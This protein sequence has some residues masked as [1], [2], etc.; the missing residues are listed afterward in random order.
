MIRAIAD[1]EIIKGTEKMWTKELL[2]D[3][4][5]RRKGQA[6][7]TEKSLLKIRMKRGDITSKEYYEIIEET[8]EYYK[9]WKDF[10]EPKKRQRR[11]GLR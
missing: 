7:K 6:L 1:L 9:E 5:L 3:S 8:K 10:K 11:Q 2:I 4:M